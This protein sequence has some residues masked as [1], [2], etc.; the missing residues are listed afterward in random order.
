GDTSSALLSGAVFSGLGA[1]DT[2]DLTGILFQSGATALVS[3][4][5]HQLIISVGGNTYDLQLGP[6]DTLA[7]NTVSVTSD[8]SG[9]TEIVLSLAGVTST[10][11]KANSPFHVHSGEIDFTD[12]VSSGGTMIVDSGG[13]AMATTVSSGGVVSV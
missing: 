9:D 10:I 2:V 3:P 8:G 6:N 13:L 1:G 7:G 11:T 4:G 12:T 5:S